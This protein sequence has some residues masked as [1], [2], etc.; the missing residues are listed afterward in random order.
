MADAKQSE[1]HEVAHTFLSRSGVE[2][3][4][5]KNGKWFTNEEL[6]EA[7]SKQN[8]PDPASAGT[9]VAQDQNP[10]MKEAGNK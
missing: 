7:T 3:H 4:L 8:D 9:P 2:V 1:G 6:A 5:T 10:T